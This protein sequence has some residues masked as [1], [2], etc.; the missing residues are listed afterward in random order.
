MVIKI[1]SERGGDHVHQKVFMGPDKD[2]LACCGDLCMRIGEWQVFGA[3]VLLGAERMTKQ[4]V[5]V[6]L[7]GEAEV[8]GIEP[9]DPY[10]KEDGTVGTYE[11][12]D[13]V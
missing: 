2:H 12:G 11:E 10:I 3:A 8:V 13:K 1:K 9:G 5:E 6:I 4:H 7:E